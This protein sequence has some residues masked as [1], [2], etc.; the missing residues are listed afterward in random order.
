MEFNVYTSEMKTNGPKF[1]ILEYLQRYLHYVQGKI[2]MYI[3]RIG[4]VQGNNY[5]HKKNWDLHREGGP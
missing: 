1:V 5:V 2:N 4:Y 3:K